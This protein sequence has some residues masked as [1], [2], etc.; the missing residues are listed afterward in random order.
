MSLK[1][2]K[3]PAE[4]NYFMKNKSKK[5]FD[6][7]RFFSLYLSRF[8][9]ALIF[10]LALFITIV[11]INLAGNYLVSSLNASFI[12]FVLMLA[13]SFFSIATRSGIFDIFA[14]SAIRFSA[15]LRPHKNDDQAFYGVYDYTKSKEVK[16]LD[17]KYFY[18]IYLTLAGIYLVVTIILY[19]VYRVNFASI[20]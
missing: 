8:L 11:V 6:F 19:I 2:A 3:K 18:L 12:S 14:Y 10:T 1:L 16:R 17:S 9:I 7:K 20:I 4:I 15:H 13:A 5:Y